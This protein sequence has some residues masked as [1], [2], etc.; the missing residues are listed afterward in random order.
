MSD[1]ASTSLRESPLPELRRRW[2]QPMGEAER[3]ALREELRARGHRVDALDEPPPSAAHL[4][5]EARRPAEE[6]RRGA[7]GRA[8]GALLLVA[9]LQGLAGVYLAAVGLSGAEAVEGA[10]AEAAGAADASATLLEAGA[11]GLLGLA[12]LGLWAWSRRAALPALGV[13]L[14]LHLALLG[15]SLAAGPEVWMRGIVV[16]AIVA[17]V[18]VAGLL[19]ARRAERG[20]AP[21][22]R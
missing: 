1:D 3:D 21:G 2:E 10:P 13:G 12:F 5:A 8:R 17:G 18:L 19:A 14:V 16:K 15:A 11:L 7:V 6:V 9:V 20:D 22:A 4:R